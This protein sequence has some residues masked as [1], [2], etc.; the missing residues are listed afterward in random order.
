MKMLQ[1]EQGQ[2]AMIVG[3]TQEEHTL[4]FRFRPQ[5]DDRRELYDEQAKAAGTIARDS[6]RYV[7]PAD[8]SIART[9]PDLLACVAIALAGPVTDTRL[10]LPLPVSQRFHSAAKECWGLNVSPVDPDRPARETPA[11]GRPALSFSG[12]IDSTAALL[13]L[14]DNA[15]SVFLQRIDPPGSR[16]NQYRV[17]AALHA[18][19]A[20]RNTGRELHIIPTDMEYLRAPVGFIDDWTVATPLVLLAD[21]CGLN[22]LTLGTILESSYLAGGTHFVDYRQRLRWRRHAATTAAV[23]LP[24]HQVTA[25]LS[26]VATSRLVMSSALSSAVQSCVRGGIGAP[27]E[28]CWKCFRKRLLDLA[29]MGETPSD[30][31]LDRYFQIREARLRL[32]ERPIKH[33]DV[34]LYILKQYRGAHAEMVQLRKRLRPDDVPLAWIARW[35]TPARAVLADLRRQGAERRLAEAYEP[36]TERDIADV[37]AWDRRLSNA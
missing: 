2:P 10:E 15:V 20:V 34:M 3:I 36:M 30:A 27:C 4:T 5:A 12:G 1:P 13:L 6:C 26:E 25:G 23:G 18:C 24:W 37:Y 9:H 7:M 14:P 28:N 29:L 21:Y 19:G 22:S 11:H 8:W 17:E 35:F 33:E 32:A 31:L 16:A